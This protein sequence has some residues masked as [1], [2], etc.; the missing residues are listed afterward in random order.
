MRDGEKE[1]ILVCVSVCFF[2]QKKNR[3]DMMKI[4]QIVT[5]EFALESLPKNCDR[6]LS[7]KERKKRKKDIEHV[8]KSFS[9]PLG[10]KKQRS[11]PLTQ[12][13]I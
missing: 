5:V 6:K 7:A 11:T 4:L 10:G 8:S 9:S 13:E 1:N 2:F 3:E 12:K